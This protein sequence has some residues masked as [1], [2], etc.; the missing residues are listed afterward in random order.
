M[1]KVTGLC[2]ARFAAAKE[3]LQSKIDAD[4]ELGASLVVNINGENV[5]DIWGG[6]TDK[7]KSKP[8]DENTITN[9]WSSSKTVLSLASL[10]LVDRGLL[11]P[12][13]NV[14]KY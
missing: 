1:A 12:V 7:E 5:V 4:E 10:L 9:A 3:L 2:D 8:W 14:S 11:D 6:Y 13:E